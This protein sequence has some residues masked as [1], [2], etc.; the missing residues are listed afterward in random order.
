MSQDEG[1]A[2]AETFAKVE[3]VKR[4]LDCALTDDQKV[5]V[6]TMTGGRDSMSVHIVNGDPYLAQE[7]LRVALMHLAPTDA[8]TM[9]RAH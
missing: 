4:I 1:R 5:V 2:G 6:V 9:R 8:E 7:M 3:E